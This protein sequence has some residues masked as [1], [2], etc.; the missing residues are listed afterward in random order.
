MKTLCAAIL[1]LMAS[2]VFAASPFDGTWLW[3]AASTELS[4]KPD[5]YLLNNGMYR[6][7]SCASPYDVPADGQDHLVNGPHD[8]DAIAVTIVDPRHVR[9]DAIKAGKPMASTMFSVS[10]DNKQLIS[11]STDLSAAAPVTSRLLSE[12]IEGGPA[13]SHTLSGSW[14]QS[15]LEGV[16]ENGATVTLKVTNMGI[17]F[18]DPTGFNYHAKFDGAEYPVHGVEG[19]RT[20]KVRLISKDM[21]EETTKQDGQ[22]VSV[23]RLTVAADGKT[24]RYVSE[25]LHEGVTTR[26]VLRKQAGKRASP[27]KEGQPR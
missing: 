23:I 11:E 25:N 6:C 27:G 13:G 8:Y 2:P 7:Q 12:R 16:S 9:V 22:V 5:I 10:S 4:D 26:G 3:D 20:V 17:S 19:N 15:R 21:F 1:C 18:T 14:R 24:A